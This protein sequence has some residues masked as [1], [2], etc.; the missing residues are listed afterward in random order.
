MRNKELE[1]DRLTYEE[2]RK[3]GAKNMEQAMLNS[4]FYRTQKGNMAT[5]LG[6]QGVLN[7][8]GAEYGYVA[9]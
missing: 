2:M 6:M 7:T 9:K 1:K 8:G 4:S 3:Q 5:S